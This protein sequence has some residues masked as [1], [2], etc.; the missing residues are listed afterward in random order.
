MLTSLKATAGRVARYRAIDLQRVL[1]RVTPPE[2]AQ[3]HRQQERRYA[4]VECFERGTVA[5]GA[6]RQQR[7]ELRAVR[8]V[9]TH[10]VILGGPAGGRNHPRPARVTR[11]MS[12]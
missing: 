7:F 2:D 6:A 10:T 11:T 3:Q 9:A 8:L 12:Q 4:R 5:G 1:R